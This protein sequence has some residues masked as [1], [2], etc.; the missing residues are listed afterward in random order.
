LQVRGDDHGRSSSAQP[1]SSADWSVNGVAARYHRWWI[2][3]DASTLD[4]G[5]W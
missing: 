3:L 4:S 1:G 2:G 5:V